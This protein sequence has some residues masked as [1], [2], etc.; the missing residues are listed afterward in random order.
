[1][2]DT[3]SSVGDRLSRYL[4]VLTK[5][6]QPVS[7]DAATLR[8]GQFH[9]VVLAGD[10]AYRFPRDEQSRRRLPG[11]VALLAALTRHHLPV[12]IPEPVDAA[13]LDQPLGRCYV[14]VRRL[15]GEPVVPSP[16]GG[17]RALVRRLAELLDALAALGT[18]AEVRR[19][20]PRAAPDQWADWSGRVRQ[21]LFPLMSA[22]GRQ[23]A[24]AEL[25]AVC[26]V[27]AAGDALVHSDLG[28]SNLLLTRYDGAPVVT[29]VLDWDEAHI[30]SQANDLAS[31]AVTFGWEVAGQIAAARGGTDRQM[32]GFARLI[33]ATFALQ[34]ALP[35]ALGGDQESLDDGLT[36]YR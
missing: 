30:G 9:D 14:A 23:R 5:D 20:A 17:G 4:S 24:E 36:G 8:S 10:A 21:V 13:H 3:V 18:C 11:R 32:I 31:L 2:P 28:G 33:A 15:R 6:G 29:G 12:T 22:S 27:P 26:T 19:V 1:M 34:Q 25:D 35:A 7:E 16:A